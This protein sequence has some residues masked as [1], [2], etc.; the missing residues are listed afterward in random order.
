MSTRCTIKG[1]G[2][3]HLYEDAIDESVWLELREGCDF[4]ACPDSVRVRLPEAAIDAIREAGQK[5]FPHL[6]ADNNK[7]AG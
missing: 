7:E 2:Q 4:V 5:K 6:R 1:G 3:W